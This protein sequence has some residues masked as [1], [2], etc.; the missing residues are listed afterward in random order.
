MKAVAILDTVGN[1]LILQ[2]CFL[3]CSL[4]LITI[5]PSAVALQRSLDDLQAGERTGMVPFA[6]HF[7]QA[8]RQYWRLGT[9]TT[10]VGAALTV[11]F[12]FWLSVGSEFGPAAQGVL[13]FWAGLGAAIYLNL[14]STSSQR[15]DL[16]ART[17]LTVSFASVRS[18]PIRALA[19]L[20]MFASWLLVLALV[21]SL[22]LAGSGLVPAVI[23]RYAVA[24]SRHP[25]HSTVAES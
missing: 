4:P 10:V 12:S 17:A 15:R 18:H 22:A 23:A 3:L 8:W 5:V 19:R 20:V 1:A 9:V 11:S 21:P 16:D 2:L 25:L 13:F 6:R 14:L 7:R 24:N